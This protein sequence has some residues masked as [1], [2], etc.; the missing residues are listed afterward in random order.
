MTWCVNIHSRKRERSCWTDSQCRVSVSKCSQGHSP[1]CRL[2]L[3]PVIRSHSRLICLFHNQPFFPHELLIPCASLPAPRHSRTSSE[4]EFTHGKISSLLNAVTWIS[5]HITH[6]HLIYSS[7]VGYEIKSDNKVSRLANSFSRDDTWLR[8][9]RI[10]A[11]VFIHL[12]L[13]DSIDTA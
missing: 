8:C 12:F 11:S 6:T 5:S 4:F 7:P 9:Q 3:F 1:F 13:C 2:S 10:N